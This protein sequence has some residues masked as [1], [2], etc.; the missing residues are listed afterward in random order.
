[1]D[2]LQIRG[3]GLSMRQRA[4][5]DLQKTSVRKTDVR[6]EFVLV[7]REILT[8][9]VN[10]IFRLDSDKDTRIKLRTLN[11]NFA[12]VIASAVRRRWAF[13]NS[14]N[15]LFLWP[16]ADGCHYQSQNQKLWQHF[17]CHLV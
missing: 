12:E 3:N 8:F 4:L 2:V 1:M 11:L 16:R 9:E 10:V 13:E 6:N 7:V 17:R 14:L 15:S 5:C